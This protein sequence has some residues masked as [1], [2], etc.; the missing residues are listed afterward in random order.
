MTT[1]THSDKAWTDKGGHVKRAEVLANLLEKRLAQ[2][3]AEAQISAKV[4]NHK[5]GTLVIPADLLLALQGQSDPAGADPAARKPVEL[6]AMDAVFAAE[7]ALKRMP[8]D[9]SAPRGLGYEIESIDAQG[10][11]FFVEVKSRA[12]GADTVTLTINEVNIGLNA[13][14]ASAWR[15]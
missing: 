11:L 3:Q 1:P 6:L 4:P 15:W 14:T 13:P 5:G 12:D 8:K 10:N 7:K 2:L 9:M